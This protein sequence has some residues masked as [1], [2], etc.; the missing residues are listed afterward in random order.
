MAERVKAEHVVPQFYLRRWTNARGKLYVFDKPSGRVFQS[1]VDGVGCETR[2]YDNPEA[3]TGRPDDQ[4]LV[5][6]Y[7]SKL[8]DGFASAFG[9]L[10]SQAD[11]GLC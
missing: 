8:E 7:L 5:E 4:Q 1:G 6:K 11:M 10:V 2:F 9:S 3:P